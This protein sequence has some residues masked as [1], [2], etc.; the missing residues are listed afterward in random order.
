MSLEKENI[1]PAAP[2]GAVVENDLQLLSYL[3]IKWSVVGTSNNN[4]YIHWYKRLAQAV[5][6]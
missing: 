4:T 5:L 2:G 1:H 3:P 6:D